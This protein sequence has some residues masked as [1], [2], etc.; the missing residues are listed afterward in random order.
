MKKKITPFFAR[1]A[2]AVLALALVFL[3]FESHVINVTADI[4]KDIIV[5]TEEITFGTVFPQEQLDKEITIAL[6]QS[7]LD[8]PNLDDVEYRIRQKPKCWNADE[9]NP[10]FGEVVET[11]EGTF[12]CEDIGFVMLPILCPYLSKTE[13]TEDGDEGQNDGESVLAFH[14]LP[15]NWTATT[16]A[17]T[18]TFGRLIESANDL[19]DL[20]N[21]DLKVPCFE[22]HCAQDWP[23][24]VLG[25]NPDA[26]PDDYVQP[27]ANEH[28]L[29]GCDLWV[30]VTATSTPP[31]CFDN[32]DLMLVLDRSGSINST[33]LAVLKNAANSFITALA[34]TAAGVH[35]GQTSFST[36]GALNLH[37]TSDEAAAHAAVNVLVAGGLT[38]LFSGISLA[39][40]ELD[41]A[42]V[43]ERPLVSDVMVVITDGAPNEPGSSANARAVA[44]AA[45]DAARAAGIE[46][47]V[48]GV[49]VNAST[50]TYLK[51]NIADDAAHYFP[52]ANFN[53]LEDIL[54]DLAT[55]T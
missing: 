4:I 25:V 18:E 43:H 40:G 29:F 15:G 12:E 11:S 45:A 48:V 51:D 38:N 23:G 46:I 36:T 41:N 13:T 39:T 8:D 50:E 28:Q 16:A 37:L 19:S 9:A 42:H 31:G 27:L 3:L 5:S 24:F 6:S 22:G 17:E 2:V 49:G 53:D 33:E 32:I 47:F 14:G 20:W 52:A 30:E 10:V 44:A 1:I 55:C 7:S 34:P 21:I 54:V 26:D 35:I